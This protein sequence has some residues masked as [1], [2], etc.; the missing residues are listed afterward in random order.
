MKSY[1][2]ESKDLPL[3]GDIKAD[4]VLPALEQCLK[5]NRSLLDSLIREVGKPSWDN[6]IRPLEVAENNLNRL[7]SP[8]SHL[9]AVVNTDELREAYNAALPILSGYSTEMGQHTD[10]FKAMRLI[11]E[12]QV[13]PPL[14][15]A[16]QKS[17]DDALKSFTRSGINLSTEK[18]QAFKAI[19]QKLSQLSSKFSDNV[20]DATNDWTLLIDDVTALK[21]LSENALAA[22]A[23]SASQRDLN[24]WLLTL[25][26][27]SFHAVM[28]YA[29][30]RALREKM[31]RAYTTRASDQAENQALN[32]ND[33]MVEILQLRQEKAELLGFDHYA[34]YSIDVK[35]A[36]SPSQI[37]S[38]LQELAEKSLPFAQKEFK[39]LQR[40][41]SENLGLD[42]LQAWD[43]AY[44]SDKLK[45]AS[46]NFSSEDLKP[47]FP[48]DYVLKGLFQIVESLYGVKIQAQDE[49][50]T[51]HED[52]RFYE[53]ID[54]SGKLI[55]QFYLDLYAR[56]HKRGGA[57]M[58]DYCTRFNN[59]SS[60]QTPVAFMTCNASSP[61]ADA[62]AL[63]THDEVITL[64]H[65]FGHGLHHMLTQIEYL[66]IS[67]ISGVEWDAV[68]LPSQFMENFCWQRET[69]DM[70][71]AHYKTGEKIPDEL[72]TKIKETQHFQSG[73]AM[74]RQLEFALFDLKIHMDKTVD[75][76]EKIQA[77]LDQTREEV[78]VIPAPDFNRFQNG[79]G[80]IF[81]GGYAAGYYSYK[82][83]EV[84]S[85]DAFS[86]FE[87]E[88][89]F[90]KQAGNDFLEQVLQQGGSRPAME[91]FVAF[92]GR[93]PKVDALL[94]HN[95]L[96]GEAA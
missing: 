73:M 37:I 68:E 31:Y 80:H 33:L 24:G 79:F 95:G 16:Q 25:E 21:G 60:I 87:E 17:L 59:G 30:D 44:A 8:V 42:R 11:K 66:S 52:V 72:F 94:R 46:F 39:A 2:P 6:F 51:W 90:S 89:L 76:A 35:M 62:P 77:I 9:N 67:G 38:F 47:Y 78:A 41:A 27:P 75:S 81:A 53:I 85:A 55:A 74:V 12:S 83:A 4:A 26:F 86:R 45:Q 92:R 23:H 10:F 91:S 57:W 69:I 93:E 36:E 43:T 28:T 3:Y 13:E 56:Q 19:S 5:D 70:F 54:S 14:N 58:A 82:W 64:F 22:A 1:L 71:A 15:A 84:L 61:T 40:F 96:T 18:Q 50:D 49:V 63:F 65:E 20:L 48:A 29:D 32:N 7:W 34:D 88:G